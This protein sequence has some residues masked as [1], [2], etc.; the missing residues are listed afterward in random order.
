MSA[1]LTTREPVKVIADILK[2][3]MG[4]ADGQIMLDYEKINILPD[5]GLY[6][7]ISY[8]GGK[9]IGNNNYFDS[10]TIKE[11]Q[12]VAMSEIVQIDI[13]SFDSSARKRKEEVI[14]ALRSVYSQQAQ[15]LNV[16]Q[17]ARIPD[18]FQNISSLEETKILNRFTMTIV[19]KALYRK[20]KSVE[21][22]DKFSDAQV[23]YNP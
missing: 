10:L 7:A 16:M 8:I 5:P 2:S 15:E 1:L 19:I 13:L 18:G 17:I 21:Y 14:M 22:Y 6:I 23:T 20:E 12:E 11:I 9:A 3:E 4:L